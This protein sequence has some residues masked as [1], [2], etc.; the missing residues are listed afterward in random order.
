MRVHNL[1]SP[2]DVPAIHPTPRW[3]HDCHRCVFLG[4]VVLNQRYDVYWCPPAPAGSGSVLDGTL[5]AR[6]GDDGPEYASYDRHT[7]KRLVLTDFAYT[8]YGTNRIEH[9]MAPWVRAVLLAV[10]SAKM[11]LLSPPAV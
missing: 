7:F 8:V 5:L 11:E 2:Y 9:D 6:Y 3:T 10:L 1:T 4:G